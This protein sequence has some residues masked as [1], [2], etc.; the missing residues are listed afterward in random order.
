MSLR[1]TRESMAYTSSNIDPGNAV[2]HQ[3][4]KDCV[5]E[6]I[7]G[8]FLF[9]CSNNSLKVFNSS[10]W[11]GPETEC[12]NENKNGNSSYVCNFFNTRNA[13]R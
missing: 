3:T 10:E 4:R 9:I 1:R 12:E 8:Y 2:A 7:N 5:G 13:Y 6:I 11:S